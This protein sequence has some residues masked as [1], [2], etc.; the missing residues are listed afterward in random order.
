MRDILV[1]TPHDLTYAN[2]LVRQATSCLSIC[3]CLFV[4]PYWPVLDDSDATGCWSGG[5][6]IATGTKGWGRAIGAQSC[7]ARSL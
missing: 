3:A 4:A 2:D 6:R 7:L 1:G 5:N